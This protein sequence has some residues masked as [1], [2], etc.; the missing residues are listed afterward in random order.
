MK[1]FFLTIVFFAG[2]I[3]ASLACEFEFKIDEKS[4]KDV[5]AAGDEVVILVKCIFTHRVCNIAI[6]DTKFDTEGFKIL[7]AT[8]WKETKPGV[9]DFTLRFVDL[10]IIF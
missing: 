7:G 10:M 6:K 8:D 3:A 4:K 1:K 5:Y 2:I 9:S